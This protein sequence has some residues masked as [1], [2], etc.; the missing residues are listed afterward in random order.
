MLPGA[1]A[2][3]RTRRFPARMWAGTSA[4]RASVAALIGLQVA[5]II[6]GR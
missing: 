5:L 2:S 6:D 1:V 3:T 4:A